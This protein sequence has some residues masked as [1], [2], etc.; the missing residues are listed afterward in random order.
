MKPVENAIANKREIA[1]SSVSIFI[2]NVGE[3]FGFFVLH[4]ARVLSLGTELCSLQNLNTADFVVVVLLPLTLQRDRLQLLHSASMRNI[5]RQKVSEGEVW[6]EP[7][8]AENV[9]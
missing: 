2:R 3:F 4:F 1:V 8:N 6:T 9:E 5:S 7:F